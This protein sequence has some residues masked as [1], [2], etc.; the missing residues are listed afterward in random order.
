MV[1]IVVDELGFASDVP[2]VE[3]KVDEMVVE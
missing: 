3:L 1:I 2:M